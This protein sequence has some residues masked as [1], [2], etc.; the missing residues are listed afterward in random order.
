MLDWV[1]PELL[2][3]VERFASQQTQWRITEYFGQNPHI[4]QTEEAIARHLGL[5]PTEVGEPLQTLCHKGLLER[6]DAHDPP[7]YRLTADPSLSAMARRFAKLCDFAA[8]TSFQTLL[9]P[10]YRPMAALNV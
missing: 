4:S 3:F 9:N 10:G 5:S 6:E 8:R 1:D 2:T 7:L